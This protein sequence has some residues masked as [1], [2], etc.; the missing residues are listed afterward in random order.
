MRLDR[1]ARQLWQRGCELKA[2]YVIPEACVGAEKFGVSIAHSAKAIGL[3][4]FIRREHLCVEEP[5][6]LADNISSD[7]T[8][9]SAS[10]GAKARDG[11][12]GGSV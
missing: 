5:R 1:E 7:V 9:R 6:C 12:T 3:A 10:A 4:L 8:E 2:G 11:A